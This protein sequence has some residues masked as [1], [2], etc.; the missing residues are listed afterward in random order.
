MAQEATGRKQLL[1]GVK[2]LD[3]TQYLA[4]PSA[5]RL[6]ADMGAEVIKIERAPDGDLG[7]KIHLVEPGISAFFLAASAGKKSVG[8]DFKH[9]QGLAI[10]RALVR[11]VDVVVENYSPGVMAKYGLDYASLKELNPGL[12]MCSVSGYGQDGPY[13]KFTSFDIVAQAQSGVMAMTGEP[14]GPPEYVGNYFGDPNA[15]IHGALGI[16]AALF[17]RALTGEGQYIDVSQLEA[18]VYLDYINFPLFLMSQG[19]IQ[20]RRFGGDFFNICPYGVYKAKQGYIV[21]AV[22]EHQWGPLVR[23]MGKPE[24][25]TDPRYATQTARCQRR[26]EVRKYIE[27]WLQTFADDETPLKIL[28]EARIPV[29]PV[30]DIAQVP[31]HPQLQARGL[32]QDLPH[33]VLGSTPVAKSPFHFSAASVEIPSRAPFF[34]EHNEEIL[35][36]RL[37]YTPEQIAALYREGAIVQEAKVRELREMGRL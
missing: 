11:Q 37:G 21:F 12:I 4:G 17:H 18:L 28:T 27:D 1:S 7:R 2:V 26:P 36:G 6:L 31:S 34:G 29:A 23:A 32:F 33:P 16:C 22:A 5:T 14:D 3:F 30:L 20:P 8:V 9:P 19:K 24:L 15:G 13:A 35:Q 10:V 25:E